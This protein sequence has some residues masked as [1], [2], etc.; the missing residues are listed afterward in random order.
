MFVGH[1]G[2]EGLSHRTIKSYLSAVRNLHI[3]YDYFTEFS[4]LMSPKLELVLRGIKKEQSHKRPPLIRLPITSEI[5]CR[6]KEALGLDPTNW[7]NIMLW[8]ACA[9]AFFGFLRCGE[10]T[11]PNGSSY[12]PTQHLSV[13][14]V[15]IDSPFNPETLQIH[16]KPSKTD[17]FRL[18]VDLFLA[19]A[20]LPLCPLVAML[21]Y[22]VIR[23]DSRGPLFMLRSGKP[24]TR[25]CFTAMMRA[26]LKK[27][28]LDDRKY[29][30]HSFRIGAATSAAAAG[31][32]DAHIKILGRW[33]SAAYQ[34]YIHM[35]RPQLAGLTQ[36]LVSAPRPSTSNS[37]SA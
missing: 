21:P 26:M 8:A 1:L 18:G 4:K 17:P 33:E 10:F 22:L 13:S 27:A 23:G 2:R 19:K 9:L 32:S 25:Q 3:T 36:Q 14:D 12:D 6:I 35:P 24:M 30:G 34:L 20:R 7:D 5:L 37:S 31:I 11:I 15:A 16:I 28:G 29:A